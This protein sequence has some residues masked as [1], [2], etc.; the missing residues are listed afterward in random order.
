[1]RVWHIDHYAAPP[2]RPGITRQYSLARELIRRGHEVTLV[3]A[4][5]DHRTRQIVHLRPEEKAKLEQIQGVPF[6]WTRAFPY[7]RNS[8]RRVINMFSFAWRAY[9]ESPKWIKGPPD[10]IVG[11]SPNPFAALTAYHLANRYGVPFVLEVRD[12]WPQTLIDLAGFSHYHPFIVILSLIERIL[13]RR[14]QAII[15]LLPGSQEFIAKKRGNSKNIYWIPNGVDF[16]LIPD[17]VP[18]PSAPPFTVM[19][20]GAHGLANGLD[21]A[22]Q[23]ARRLQ[24]EG[25]GA[26]VQFRF[27]GDGPEK[28][29]L[30][31]QARAWGLQNV[32]FEDPVPKKEVY[33]RLQQAHSF[34]MILRDSPLFR[35]GISPN[36][37]FDFMAMARPVLFCVRTP[38]NP[39]EEHRAGLTA[40]P[41]NPQA[42]AEAIRTL[43][44]TPAEERWAMGL[45]ARAYVEQEHDLRKLAG[46]FEKVLLAVIKENEL[47]T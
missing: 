30:V 1:M 40:P 32:I 14:A 6:L 15:T 41:D 23:A 19:Y 29:R 28:P 2:T 46:R 10:I 31:H 33:P 8:I 3:A 24:E 36:K 35:W 20:A 43:A 39:I 26:R 47:K 7:Q 9:K 45:R 21:I 37:L 16:D 44:Q 17:P 27:I 22:L 13:Y 42:L 12:L 11:T 4:A 25:W 18:P 34:L 5:F 38:Y